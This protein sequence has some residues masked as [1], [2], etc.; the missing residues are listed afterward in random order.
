MVS[1]DVNITFLDEQVSRIYPLHLTVFATNNHYLIKVS[2][3]VPL[4]VFQIV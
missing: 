2:F 4:S 1:A 3:S